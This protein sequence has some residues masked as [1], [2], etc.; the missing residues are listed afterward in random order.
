M[1]S[2]A[3]TTSSKPSQKSKL[4]STAPIDSTI[5]IKDKLAVRILKELSLLPNHL[6]SFSVKRERFEWD[7]Y[8]F[9]GHFLKMESF[10]YNKELGSVG[11]PVEFKMYGLGY[12]NT[13]FLNDGASVN[14]NLFN[15]YNFYFASTEDVDEIQLLPL[16][17]GFLFGNTNNPTAVNIQ[18]RH[19]FEKKAYSRIK[20]Y[21]A[22]NEEGMLDAMFSIN[23]FNKLNAFFEI[24]NQSTPSRYNNSD[25]SSWIGKIKL[26]YLLSNQINLKAVYTVQNSTIGLN[27]GVNV[28]SIK[29]NVSTSSQINEILFNY[30]RAPVRYANRYITNK[31]SRFTFTAASNLIANA[32]NQLTI[33]YDD[34]LNGFRQN[35]GVDTT[36]KVD[37]VFNDNVTKSF[38]VVFSQ[39]LNTPL[40]EFDITANFDRS[41]FSTPYLATEL[42]QSSYSV[43]FN[44]SLIS[45]GNFIIPGFFTKYLRY[46]G[47]SYFGWGVDALVNFNKEFSLYG[48]L[49][50]FQ[51]PY[52][53]LEREFINKN[54][55]NPFQ[56]INTAELKFS[57]YN[58][59]LNG[60]IGF[61]MVDN[62]NRLQPAFDPNSL[63]RDES[64]YSGLND[65]NLKGINFSLN[66]KLWKLLATTNTNYYLNS[67]ERIKARI[68][69]FTACGGI[70]YID[71]LFNNSLHLKTGFNYYSTGYRFEERIDFEKSLSSSFY[72]NS[73]NNSISK[74]G[75]STFNPSFQ[76][77]YFLAGRIQERAIIYIVWENILNSQYYIVSYYPVQPRGIRF[78][79]AWEFLD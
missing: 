7:D 67:D 27:G 60:S 71:T 65:L 55:L 12:G 4:V 2:Q 15:S 77:D 3:D 13:S 17:R 47:D 73:A 51:K 16:P 41:K 18:S 57:Y 5:Q 62:Q 68:P 39:E 20:F 28:D 19:I 25:Y 49:S 42:S 61:F 74:I 43:S 33:Y 1:W 63:T 78:G 14:N 36:K 38:G 54:S 10:I 11:L 6:A 37:R 58:S 34:I 40:A 22:A 23:P 21:Q 70:F 9:S 64:I 52:S 44:G 72:F 59:N 46:A 76:L 31:S 50:Q 56:K 8:R 79:V 29:K 69:K 26:L 75:N 32:P 48:G 53:V 66:L 35:I 24:M 30:L 45:F